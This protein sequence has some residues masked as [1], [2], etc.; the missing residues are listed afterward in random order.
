MYPAL[1]TCSHNSVVEE[2]PVAEETKVWSSRTK[3][4]DFITP[5]P[6]AEQVARWSWGGAGWEIKKVEGVAGFK[7]EEYNSASSQPRLLPI[8]AWRC[9]YTILLA[10]LLR[11]YIYVYVYIYLCMH[12]YVCVCIYIYMCVYVY[13]FICACTCTYTYLSD[14]HYH[15]SRPRYYNSENVRNC[16][17]LVSARSFQTCSGKKIDPRVVYQH[18]LSL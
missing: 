13:M 1:D 7:I 2:Q 15:E 3:S 18:Y 5:S 16:R 11:V 8:R 14:R 10:V 4:T 6:A 12:I 17:Q 9:S